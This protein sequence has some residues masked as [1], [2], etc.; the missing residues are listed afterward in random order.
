M[1]DF[2]SEAFRRLFESCR[3][4]GYT[5][6]TYRD[7]IT[8]Q[9]PVGR[10]LIL[11]HD[12]DDRPGHALAMALLE[13]EINVKAS[14]YFRDMAHTFNPSIIA[15]IAT[16]G[17]EIGYHYENMSKCKGNMETAYADF[18]RSLAKFREVIPVHTIC[19]HGR[20]MS[21]FDNTSL[22]KQYDYKKAGIIADIN[23]DT[24]FTDILY[25][26]DTG[27]SWNSKFN[28]RDKVQ[29]SLKCNARTTSELIGLFNQQALPEKIVLNI[30]PQRWTDNSYTWYRDMM[31]QSVRNAIK[32]FFFMQNENGTYSNR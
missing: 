4:N 2:T 15:E 17:H 11:R 20:P 10:R 3:Q 22:W 32:Y 1:R 5:I 29:S 31:A 27:R 28:R 6:S 8:G 24:D 18:N 23:R 19:A 25:L 9:L 7:F 16:L 13:N 26:T 14:Y 12:V 30:H 21:G